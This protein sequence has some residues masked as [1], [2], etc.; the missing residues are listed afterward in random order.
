MTKYLVRIECDRIRW[1][2]IKK[3]AR[4]FVS[5]DGR[6]Y[7]ND[8]ALYLKDAHSSDAIRVTPIDS[9][10]VGRVRPMIVNPD[11]T[12]AYIMSKE[13]AGTKKKSW[14]NLDASKIWMYLVGAIVV[15][16]VAWTILTNGGF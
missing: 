1:I 15:G 10:Q 16:V 5:I 8:D 7:R 9:N 6:L 14:A 12:R 3:A 11:D 2:R 13:I 4:I